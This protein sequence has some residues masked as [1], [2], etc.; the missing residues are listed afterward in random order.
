MT[1]PNSHFVLIVE[2]TDEIALIIQLTL[3]SMGIQ[4]HRVNN[5]HK[6]LDTLTEEHPDLLL[7]DIGLPGMSG[8]E[9]LEAIK[10]RYP[11][12]QFPVI[13]LTAFGDPAN[14]LIGKFQP[15]VVR[16][17]VK[18]FDMKDLAQA[19]REALQM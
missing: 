15:H 14:R 2:D 5:G 18:P 6:A 7:L 8:W 10:T 11:D 12:A 3:E 9:L 16:Y 1:T 4:S 13:V 19:V 17:F